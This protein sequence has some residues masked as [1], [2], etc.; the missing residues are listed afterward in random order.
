VIDEGRLG[1]EIRDDARAS[2]AATALMALSDGL[3][4]Q[5]ACAPFYPAP[6]NPL[7]EADRLLASWR[8]TPE[9][10]SSRTASFTNG[11]PSAH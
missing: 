11:Q 7:A 5:R 6:G 2:D 3:V 8:S 10:G 9:D 1:G 4:V